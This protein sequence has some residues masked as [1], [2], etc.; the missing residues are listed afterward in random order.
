[1]KRTALALTLI[2]ALLF[3]AVAGP[4]LVDL[5]EANWFVPVNPS[6][7]P[8]PE[9]SILLPES[10]KKYSSNI[11]IDF[12]VTGPNWGHYDQ[13]VAEGSGSTIKLSSFSYSLD[14]KPNVTFAGE[15][16]VLSNS[17][18]I[19]FRLRFLGNL[20]GLSDGL[21][22]IVVYAQAEGRYSPDY[23]KLENFMVSGSSPKTFFTVGVDKE[24]EPFPIESVIAAAASSVPV[25]GVGLLVYLLKSRKKRSQEP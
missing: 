4:K 18:S 24:P 10:N 9:I 12:L 25:I 16:I 14:D 23:Y 11:G 5:A 21:H 17:T 13:S 3:S 1:M 15:Q 22:S 6:P 20:S 2:M 8:K 7:P 19:V